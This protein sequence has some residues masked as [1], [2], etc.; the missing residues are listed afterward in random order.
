V[1]LFAG[2]LSLDPR[3]N[4]PEEAVEELRRRLSRHPQDQPQAHLAG[5]A[6]LFWVDLGLCE[7]AGS[8]IDEQ[9]RV[10]LYGAEPI[11][12]GATVGTLHA[13]WSA[14]STASLERARG[15]FCGVHYDPTERRLWLATDKLGLRP[16][17][18][19]RQGPRVVFASALRILDGFSQIPAKGELQAV[20]ETAC[21]GYPLASRTPLAGV[22][23]VEPGQ[24]VELTPQGQRILSY[25]EWQTAPR[26][27]ATEDAACQELRA[28]FQDAV[29]LR[30]GSRRRVPALL[31]G[32]LDSRCVVA[33]LREAGAQVDTINFGPE[34]SADLVLG[35]KAADAL[36]THHFELSRGSHDFWSRLGQAYASWFTERGAACEAGSAR[37]LWS[38]EGGD[39]VLAPVNLSMAI[40]KRMR[41]NE[42][43]K[44]IQ[45]YMRAERAS[46]PRRLFRS[47][48]RDWVRNLPHE[49]MRAQLERHAHADPARRFHLYVLLNESRR[50]IYRHFE[51][52]DLN[53]FELVMPFYDSEMVAAALSFPFEPFIGHR[54][55]YRWLSFLPPAVTAVAWQPYPSA[56][57]CPVPLP[58]EARLQWAGWYSRT[59][60]KAQ[61]RSQLL[62]AR[63]LL[64]RAEFPHWILNRPVLTLAR[65]L[66]GLGLQ[67]YGYMFE[68]ARPFVQYPPD[69]RA[70]RR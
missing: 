26:T 28:R 39:R 54:L 24:V 27:P 29:R 36:G 17:Y 51:D 67:R 14:R 70:M 42:L 37:L 59:E 46:L 32:G 49:G 61:W 9:G 45:K 22:Y 12:G 8:A 16:L 50:N 10:S 2:I 30:L 44:A 38:G 64:A 11:E 19:F 65:L 53:R 23:T 56:P 3:E 69:A 40:V 21:F 55:Y 20:A 13:E 58:P 52:L 47:S 66:L 68:V 41:A 48:A 31:S 43:D 7:G 33:C 63:A 34:G 5:G 6:A 60:Q 18:Y 15:S 25:H 62:L 1:T 35:R 57:P 4:P